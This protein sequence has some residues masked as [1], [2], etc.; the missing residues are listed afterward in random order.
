MAAGVQHIAASMQAVTDKMHSGD[1][2][3]KHVI[4]DMHKQMAK[5]VETVRAAFSRNEMTRDM[6][7]EASGTRLR[8]LT[9]LAFGGSDRRT[10]SMGSLTD[11]RLASLR[12]P[13]AGV[14]PVHWEWG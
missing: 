12:M 1:E 9:S 3:V 10:I 8:N 4:G 11:H 2:E 6:I 5:V 7:V 14:K 13:V